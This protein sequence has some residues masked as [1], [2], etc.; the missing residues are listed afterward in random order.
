[1]KLGNDPQA[2][3]TLTPLERSV[4]RALAAR[5]GD[6][7]PLLAAQCASARVVNRSH[8]G[9]GFVTR[10]AIPDDVAGLPAEAVS[11]MGPVHARHPGL[12]DAAEFLVQMKNGRLG[13]IEAWC[14]EGMWPE[15]DAGFRIEGPAA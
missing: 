2:L 7:G 4:L 1:M 11:R 9:V 13:S 5:V 10:L 12:P 3:L 15:D 8:S 14:R 6:A